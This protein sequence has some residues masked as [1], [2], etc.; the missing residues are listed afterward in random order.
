M[1]PPGRS[2]GQHT[3]K[4]CSWNSSRWIEV[5]RAALIGC[6][7]ICT[8]AAAARLQLV[9]DDAELDLELA[10][11]AHEAR[12]PAHQPTALL[13]PRVGVG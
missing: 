4:T 7:R 2:F 10:M 8:S 5:D 12:Q 6:H 11:R 9:V 1:R 3:G 13:G